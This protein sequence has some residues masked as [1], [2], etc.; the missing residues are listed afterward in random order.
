MEPL[1]PPEWQVFRITVLTL[2]ATS[3]FS[4]ITIAITIFLLV[5]ILF[6]AIGMLFGAPWVPSSKGIGRKM[7]EMGDVKPGEIVYDL[8]SGDGRLVVLAAREFKAKATGIEINPFWVFWTRLAVV[9]FRLGHTVRIIWGNFYDQD[10]G[11]ADIVL[12]YLLQG[13]N[14]SIRPKLERELR[15]GTRIISHVYTF[16]GWKPEKSDEES[17]IYL[18]RR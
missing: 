16:D 18:Y 13:T 5:V 11:E 7:L 3:I 1:E 4:G 12:L 15:P 9:I 6:M 17:D 2:L 14:A 10:L 8:G